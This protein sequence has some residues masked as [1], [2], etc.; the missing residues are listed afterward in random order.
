MIKKNANVC[1]DNEYGFLLEF[2]IHENRKREIVNISVPDKS[3]NL[4][5]RRQYSNRI[6]P[7]IEFPSKK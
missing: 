4:G 6:E 2:E 5:D 7:N 3:E 1:K